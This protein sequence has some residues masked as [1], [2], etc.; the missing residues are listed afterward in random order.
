MS[1][2]IKVIVISKVRVNIKLNL[3]L[4]ALN[5]TKGYGNQQPTENDLFPGQETE[6]KHTQA[7]NTVN[8]E[9]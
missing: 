1:K 9:L 7:S 6:K 2:M 4:G 3:I 5:L 8:S